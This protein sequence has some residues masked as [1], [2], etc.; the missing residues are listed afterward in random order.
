MPRELS[1]V[2]HYFLPVDAPAPASPNAVTDTRLEPRPP[3]AS[4]AE[5]EARPAPVPP[6]HARSHAPAHAHAPDKRRG[7]V[8]PT[9]PIVAVPVAFD[10]EVRAA[11]L[12]N[13]SIE[14]ARCG[15]H[16][17]L[18]RPARPAHEPAQRTGESTRS[19]AESMW[20]PPGRQPLGAEL[21]E[22]RARNLGDLYRAA[23]DAALLRS[24]GGGPGLVLVQTP[25]DWLAAPGDGAPL[26]EWALLL[27]R[28]EPGDLRA[29]WRLA[30]H[31]TGARPGGRL[32]ITIHGATSRRAA[33]RGFAALA[34]AARERLAREVASYGLL[35]DDLHVYRAITDRRPIGVSQPQSLAARALHDVAG[36]LL[37]DAAELHA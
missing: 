7:A 25:A 3:A 17:L 29:T 9:L 1:D 34:R 28:S 26:L 37:D 32:G 13:L 27:T 8:A 10:D 5:R 2:L 35:A 24:G 31:L 22:A 23:V 12:W 33:E 36:T 6:D 14:I 4:D 18:L 15:G 20:P 19:S 11:L 16:S 30:R 21:I